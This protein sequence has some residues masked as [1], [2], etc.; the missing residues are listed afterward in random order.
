MPPRV[1][2]G[3]PIFAGYEYLDYKN[4]SSEL[5]RGSERRGCTALCGDVL[6]LGVR[7]A[8]HFPSD[9]TW[10]Y[11]DMHLR[12]VLCYRLGRRVNIGKVYYPP[13]GGT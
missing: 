2:H 1:L 5:V 9:E 8:G 11:P 13:G 10:V 7:A 6:A 4:K 12:S 3:L